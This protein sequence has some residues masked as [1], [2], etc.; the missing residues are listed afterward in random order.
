MRVIAGSARRMRLNTP[1]GEA[2]RPTQDRIKETLFNVIQ[3]E[4]PGCVFV[5]IC[6]GSGG[7]GI[8][9]LSRGARKAYFLENAREPL[10]YLQQNLE[11]THLSDRAA[12]LK[13]D[14]VA[15]LNSIKDEADV[16]YIDPPYAS[17]LYEELLS[18]LSGKGFVTKYTLI[19]AEADAD[20]D[21][22]FVEELGFRVEKEKNYKHNKH[23]FIRR[24][25][26]S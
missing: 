8:E 17:P 11:A 15:A 4:I 1:T 22:A 6:C 19:I 18:A 16:I 9:A 2:T 13:G 12:V 14:A 25:D 10:K 5:D 7:I 24:E 23:V 21:F 3:N 20:K 26:A